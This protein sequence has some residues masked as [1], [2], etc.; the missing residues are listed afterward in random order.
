MGPRGSML[1]ARARTAF[2]EEAIAMAQYAS[3]YGQPQQPQQLFQ[4]QPQPGMPAPRPQQQ[5]ASSPARQSAFPL[6]PQMAGQ[7]AGGRGGPVHLNSN[8]AQRYQPY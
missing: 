7:Q 3:A 4:M 8:R 5:Q 1:D 2:A 6:H